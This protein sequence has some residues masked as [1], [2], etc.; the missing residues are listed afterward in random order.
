MKWLGLEISE[1]ISEKKDK[2]LKWINHYKDNM[3]K[4]QFT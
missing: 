4:M 2:N 1:K 3:I